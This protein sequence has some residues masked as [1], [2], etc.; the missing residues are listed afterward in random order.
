MRTHE[1]ACV[2]IIK[3]AY[4]AKIMRTG[5]LPRNH[6]NTKTKAELQNDKSK[7][8]KLRTNISNIN[9]IKSTPKH[10]LDLTTN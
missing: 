10:A 1:Q 4:A 8:P 9:K 3:P 6:S 2:H 7:Q 5:F